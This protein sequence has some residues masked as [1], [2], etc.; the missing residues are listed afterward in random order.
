MEYVALPCFTLGSSIKVQV[1]LS[2]FEIEMHIA[3]S[4]KLP[5]TE[6]FASSC[7]FGLVLYAIY[8]L[9]YLVACT[10]SYCSEHKKNWWISQLIEHSTDMLLRILQISF[11]NLVKPSFKSKP[12]IYLFIRV[13]QYK[14]F[15]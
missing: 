5:Y 8:M 14:K 3:C 11:S 15:S 10:F 2:F 7:V 4:S 13:N 1:Q 6:S 9:P 12:K